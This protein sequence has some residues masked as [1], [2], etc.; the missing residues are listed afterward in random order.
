MSFMGTGN[1]PSN[2]SKFKKGRGFRDLCL[3]LF[4][5]LFSV[6]LIFVVKGTQK[7][8]GEVIVAING[9]EVARYSLHLDAQYSLNGGTNL[10]VIE[11][12]RARILD[13]NCPGKLCVK[14]GWIQY[15]GQCITCLPNELTVTV[16]GGDSSVDIVI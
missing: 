7:A 10:L 13:A 15:T 11:N 16:A 1:S 4:L 2:S 6:V 8:G 14:Q 5:L 3:V 12:G 9:S